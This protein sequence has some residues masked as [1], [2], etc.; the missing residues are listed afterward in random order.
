MNY[1]RTFWLISIG[2]V[3][4]VSR[5]ASPKRLRPPAPTR[6][7]TPKNRGLKLGTGTKKDTKPR[8]TAKSASSFSQENAT[9]VDILS[10][11]TSRV[12]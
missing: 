2:N 5:Q 8:H 6:A 7:A 10:E 3:A 11:T 1:E 4:N 12:Q 9:D